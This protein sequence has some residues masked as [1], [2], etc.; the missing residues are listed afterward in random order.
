MTPVDWARLA[1]AG[2]GQIS[3]YEPGKPLEELER[4]LGIVDAIKLASNENPWGSSPLALQAMQRAAADASRYPDG[5]GYLL[6]RRLAAHLGVDESGITLG[7]GSN[8]VIDLVARAFLAP[9]R[10]AVV[11][12]HCFVAY[13]LSTLASGAELKAAPARDFGHDPEA[14]L[15]CIDADTRVVF[16]ANPNNPTGTWLGA[17]GL[18]RLLDGVPDDVIVLLDQAYLEYFDDP[19]YLDGITLLPRYP[20]LVVTRTFSK[21][22]GLAALRVGYAVSSAGIADLLNRV[23]MPFNVSS[24]AQAAA[25]AA[26]DDADF[27]AETR[28]RNLAGL[29]QLRAG[30][31]RMGLEAIH[32]HGNFVT[33]NCHQ[34]GAEVYQR[35]LREG[36]IVRP[37]AGYGLPE[38]LRVSVGTRAENQRALDAFARVL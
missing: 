20:N 35:L 38:H 31:E 4:E 24:V 15:A 28:A 8:E 32:G 27:V 9:G 23:R 3:P 2:V 16:L 29:A 10:N 22:Y 33:V 17:A 1:H 25:T 18:T 19:D 5:S 11:S 21:I 7:N 13:V 6:R 12:E 26:L 30:F 36:V 37:I 34:S 14:M